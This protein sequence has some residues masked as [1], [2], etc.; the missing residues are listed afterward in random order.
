MIFLF[1]GSDIA[2]APWHAGSCSSHTA[3]YISKYNLTGTDRFKMQ[4]RLRVAAARSLRLPSPWPVRRRQIP[5]LGHRPERSG[6]GSVAVT[7]YRHRVAPESNRLMVK[8]RETESLWVRVSLQAEN[9][10]AAAATTPR[11]RRDPGPGWS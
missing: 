10:A 5:V 2:V 4:H 1:A 3:L 6:S 8:P 7:T 11:Q 9:Y